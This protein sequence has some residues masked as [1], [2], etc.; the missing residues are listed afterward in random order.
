MSVKLNALKKN[1]LNYRLNGFK[2]FKKGQ[3]LTSLSF[4]TVFTAIR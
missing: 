2:N 1:Q 4:F 3:L